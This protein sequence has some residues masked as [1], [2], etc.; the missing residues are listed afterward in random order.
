[1]NENDEDVIHPGILIKI[2]KNPGIQADFVIR[3]PQVVALS[4]ADPSNAVIVVD[5]S[6]AKPNRP[7]PASYTGLA[8]GRNSH[9]QDIIYAPDFNILQV[10]S[11]EP[12]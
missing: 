11:G 5:Y 6:A 12:I 10:D 7:P 1:M 2:S 3:H 4:T 9:G 8:I